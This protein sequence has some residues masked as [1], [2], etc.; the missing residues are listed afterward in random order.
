ML[1]AENRQH[2]KRQALVKKQQKLRHFQMQSERIFR[3]SHRCPKQHVQEDMT[4]LHGNAISECILS[5]KWRSSAVAKHSADEWRVLQGSIECLGA[6]APAESPD[7]AKLW[8]GAKRVS[9]EAS[10]WSG[11]AGMA[12]GQLG[13]PTQ[14]PLAARVAAGR[15][16]R[17]EEKRL[18]VLERADSRAPSRGPSA[19]GAFRSNDSGPAKDES[20]TVRSSR[21]GSAAQDMQLHALRAE[22]A[23][24]KQ[25]VAEL[26]ELIA[27]IERRNCLTGTACAHQN[28]TEASEKVQ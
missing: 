17:A 20:V 10:L 22:L 14:V 13:G 21:A 15:A 1:A 26:E 3:Q 18:A 5:E 19:G 27:G 2:W 23:A 4:C 6:D 8:N 7:A 24:A 16:R 25:T 28:A 9:R 12:V 11:A